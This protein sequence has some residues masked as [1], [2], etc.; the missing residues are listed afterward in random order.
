[1]NA[2][3]ELDAGFAG[4]TLDD[5]RLRARALVPALRERA[6][7]Q[8]E[9]RRLLPENLADL[10][11]NGLLRWGQPR[12]WGGMELDFEA[13]FD[14]PYEVGRGCLSTAWNVGNLGIHHWM[15]ALYDERAQN[16]VWG[17]NRDALIA[18]GIAFPQGSAKKVD[19][20]FLLSGH[21]NFSSG[22]DGSEWNMLACLVKDGDRV[23][24]HRMCLVPASDYALI[25][26][27]QV[28]GM[29]GTG[30]KSVKVKDAFVP[31]HRALCMYLARGEKTYPG[32]AVNDNPVYAVPLS[33]WGGHC[34][35]GAIVGNAQAAVDLTIDSIKARS[36][37]Y[38][39]MRMRDFQAVQ[40]RVASAAAQVEAACLMLRTDCAEGQR[41]AASGRAP[42]VEEKL[43]IKRNLAFAIGLC[44]QAVDQMHALAGANG[45]YDSYPIQRMFRDHHAAMA[46][47]SF[48]WDAQGGPWGLVAMGGEF[49]SP[50][51]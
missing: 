7:R 34:L 1:M 8:E 50:T 25:D 20:G 6:G 27:W 39:A 19:G 42:T 2:P 43:R 12:T 46:H 10:N 16:E 35:A 4:L 24:D 30:S 28:L 3:R 41:I 47:I 45:I 14:V 9:A 29:R 5:A 15:L 18:S 21:W 23:V 36:T 44:T 48:S 22:V 49:P 17:A 38:T 26:D 40:L 51:L 32:A 11:A 37:A 31:E 33:S 13:V